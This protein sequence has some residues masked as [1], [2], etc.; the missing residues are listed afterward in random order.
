MADR[1]RVAQI[2][3]AVRKINAAY[4]LWASAHGLSLYEMQVYYVMT[5]K[6]AS[7]ITQRDL[8]MELDAPKTSI[9]G[10][11][12]KQIGYGYMKME[13]NPEN[14]REKILSLTAKGKAFA[15]ELIEPLFAYEAEA[16]AQ[17]SELEMEQVEGVQ[18]RF[19]DT[20]LQKVGGKE[21]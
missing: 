21:A 4:E 11:I 5:E 6:K 19:A 17:F 13:T 15:K 18:K 10:I 12:K 2:Y 7:V 20:L 1:I 3:D 9:N 16:A 8:C 14:R